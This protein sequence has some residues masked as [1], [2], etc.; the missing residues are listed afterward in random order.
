MSALTTTEN[1]A[2]SQ[3]E[4][5]IQ[6]GL[7]GFA[8][9]GASLAAIKKGRLYRDVADTFEDY[10]K[11]RWGFKRAHAY[12]LIEAAGIVAEMSPIGRQIT[13][14]RQARSLKDVPANERN[15]IVENAA[16]GGR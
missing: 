10:C 2:L 12:R 13:N 3:H 5:V 6:D 11:Q 8:Q 7:A 15:V 14:E 16:A 4:A 1:D 9:V